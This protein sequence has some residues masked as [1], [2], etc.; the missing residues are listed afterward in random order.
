MP[1]ALHAPDEWRTS[2]LYVKECDLALEPYLDTINAV[3]KRFSPKTVKKGMTRKQTEMAEDE[4]IRFLDDLRLLDE[5][6][7]EVSDRISACCIH[8]FNEL[9]MFVV[10][11]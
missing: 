2:R 10:P 1:V 3:F 6:F 7:S 9:Y 8:F 4:F 11:R 5:Q